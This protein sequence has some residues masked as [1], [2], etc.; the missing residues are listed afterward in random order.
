MGL[1]TTGDF[2]AVLAAGLVL[3]QGAAWVAGPQLVVSPPATFAEI[4]DLL[5][6]PSFWGNVEATVV[7][8]VCAG[9]IAVVLG[10]GLGTWLGNSRGASDT[11]EPLLMSL[12][13][14]PKV[15]LYPIILMIC[16][17]GLSA[18][19]TFGVL[20]GMVPITLFTMGAVRNIPPIVR[21]VGHLHNLSPRQ[22]LFSLLIPAALPEIFSGIRVGLSV[23]LLGVVLGEMFASTRGLGSMLMSAI[24]LANLDA[25]AAITL[26]LVV[27]ATVLSV[28][29]T[30]A[31]HHLHHRAR[32]A[33]AL[34]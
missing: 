29:M 27:A 24:G 28:A 10:V 8:F 1:R 4:G 17:L 18:K 25:V 5:H 32:A 31:D 33:G 26:I 16:G 21:R 7:A 13:S 22:Q 6:R 19:I 9:A 2:A 12:G 3:W 15:T 11:G 30:W 14:L 20:H 34:V 23:T